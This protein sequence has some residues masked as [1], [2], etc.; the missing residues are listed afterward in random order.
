MRGLNRSVAAIVLACS[1]S[2]CAGAAEPAPAGAPNPLDEI[3]E[4]MP[5]NASYGAPI[6][7]EAAQKL[8]QAATDEASK[9]GWGMSVAVVDSGGTLV[10]FARMGAGH[11]ASAQIA[12]DKAVAAVKFR[13]PTRVFED[14]IQK[15]GF[16]YLITLPGLVASRGGI[17]IVEDGKITGAIG[18]SSG[19]GSQDEAV[20][21]AALGMT[22]KK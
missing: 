4:A 8:I 12:Q 7:L 1:T 19:T 17:P 10:A 21:M 16:N 22:E 5:F 11:L 20:C 15:K 6:S 2:I 18:C 14:A 9:R 13:R 3:P